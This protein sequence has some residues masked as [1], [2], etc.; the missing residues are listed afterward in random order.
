MYLRFIDD[1]HIFLAD[2]LQQLAVFLARLRAF[3]QIG[4]VGQGVAQLLLAP[5]AAN[6][7]VVAIEQGLGDAQAG[8]LCPIQ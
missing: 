3:Q 5:P 4:A 1:L 2:C 7:G 8:E 6:S